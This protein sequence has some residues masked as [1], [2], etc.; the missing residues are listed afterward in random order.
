MAKKSSLWGRGSKKPIT[1]VVTSDL[2]ALLFW[3]GVGVADAT[4]GAYGEEIEAI[5]ESYAE[6]IA[7]KGFDRKPKFQR[8]RNG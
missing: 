6:H 8:R 3:A 4:G 7:F 2:R 1:E 5:I